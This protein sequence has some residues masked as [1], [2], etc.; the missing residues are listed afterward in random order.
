[1]IHFAPA[2]GDRVAGVG[3]YRRSLSS[4]WHSIVAGLALPVVVACGDSGAGQKLDPTA[5]GGAGGASGSATSASD[6]GAAGG[7]EGTTSSGGTGSN[8]TVGATSSG[9]GGSNPENATGGTASTGN[10]VST[11]GS[12]GDSQAEDSCSWRDTAP[13]TVSTPFASPDDS[14]TFTPPTIPC[15]IVDVTSE[16]VTT[17][18]SSAENR[19]A[20]NQA[21]S[22]LSD[23]GGGV[24]DVP[25]GTYRIGAITLMS[26]I[27][28]RLEEGAMLSFSAETSDYEPPVL[29]RW[30]GLD[31]INWQPAVYALGAT[32]VAITGQGNLHGPGMSWGGGTASWKANSSSAAT[33]VYDEWLNGNVEALK[34][35]GPPTLDNMTSLDVPTAHTENGLR[36][37][38]VE[39]NGCTNFMVEG[40]LIDGG[41]YW[42]IHPLYSENVIVRNLTVNSN[43]GSSNGDGTNPDSSTNVLIDNVTYNTSDDMIAIKSGTNEPGFNIARPSH[44]IV[45]HDIQVR[46]G[47]GFSIG[48]E[49]SGGVDNVYA[50][51]DTQQ[52][53]TGVQYLLRIKTPTGRGDV[54]IANV[55]FEDVSGTGTNNDVY[56]TTSYASAAIPGSNSLGTPTFS[57]INIVNVR[58]GGSSSC[59]TPLASKV[60]SSLANNDGC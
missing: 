34:T 12:G 31:C 47:H 37:T 30:E 33:V 16:G 21:I 40:V 56:L 52:T 58:G 35:T 53:W 7:T 20:M 13:V 8:G 36:P 48:S 10:S 29:T 19:T 41:W 23:A 51:N 50:Y 14:L 18:G 9:A 57:N 22:A 60:D 55:W 32:N 26:N 59:T 15:N 54:Q 27:E 46:G 49:L 44:N 3:C 24:I 38:F 4:R 5:A 2:M 45:A 43:N 42:N 17:S 6:D 25:S 39:C 11:G 28:L 1:M